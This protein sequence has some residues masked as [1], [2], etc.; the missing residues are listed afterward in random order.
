MA[1]GTAIAERF[2][3]ERLH[4]VSLQ[5]GLNFDGGVQEETAYG[6]GRGW[7]SSIVQFDFIL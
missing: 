4:I 5:N 2:M 3:V 6:V 1:L 7:A